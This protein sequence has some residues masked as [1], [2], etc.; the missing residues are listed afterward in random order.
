MLGKTIIEM[1]QSTDSLS[2]VLTR[3]TMQEGSDPHAGRPIKN[4]ISRIGSEADAWT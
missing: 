3:R 2:T 1:G 4:P